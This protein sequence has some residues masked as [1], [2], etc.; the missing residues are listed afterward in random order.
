M[1]DEFEWDY[2]DAERVAVVTPAG[3]IS[4]IDMPHGAPNEIR[5]AGERYVKSL[6][7]SSVGAPCR[8]A[9]TKSWPIEPS[10]QLKLAKAFEDDDA[11]MTRRARATEGRGAETRRGH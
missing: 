11:A 7:Q 9:F 8:L 3:G 10:H 4:I 1:R 2:A 6:F 5:L